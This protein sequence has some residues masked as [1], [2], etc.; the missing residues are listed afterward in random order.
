MGKD[1]PIGRQI[2]RQKFGKLREEKEKMNFSLALIVMGIL[3]MMDRMGTSYGLRE[4]W[5]WIVIALGAGG[6]FKDIRS[7]PAWVTTLIGIL[8]LNSNYYSIHVKFPAAIKTYFL[9]VLMIVLGIIWI[10]RYHKD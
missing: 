5:P 1:I 8:V 2:A 6:L 3:V 4:G 10:W 7:V 9:P